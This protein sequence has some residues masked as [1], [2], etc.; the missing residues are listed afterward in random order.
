[1]TQSHTSAAPNLANT[2]DTGPALRSALEKL[3]WAAVLVLVFTGLSA[4]LGRGLFLIEA[5][6]MAPADPDAAFN[7][8]DVRYSTTL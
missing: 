8:F 2:H 4:I 6:A 7:A 5:L 3:G 1:M